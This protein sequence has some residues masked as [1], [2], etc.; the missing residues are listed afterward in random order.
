MFFEKQPLHARVCLSGSEL[1]VENRPS[2]DFA[3]LQFA[4]SNLV[5]HAIAEQFLLHNPLF[6]GASVGACVGLGACPCAEVTEGRESLRAGD[7]GV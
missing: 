2:L 4:D 5:P 7:A 6:A 3:R 1:D